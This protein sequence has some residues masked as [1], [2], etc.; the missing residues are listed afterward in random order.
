VRFDLD[1]DV[2]ELIDRGG[3][4]AHPVIHRLAEEAGTAQWTALDADGSRTDLGVLDLGGAGEPGATEWDGVL[5]PF[6]LDIEIPVGT[7]AIDVVS[8]GRLELDELMI[9]PAITSAAYPLRDG[10]ELILRAAS[11]ASTAETIPGETGSAYGADGT[12][13]GPVNRGRRELS[14]GTIAIT[15]R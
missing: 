2:Q 9:L 13:L 10:G 14:A 11:T 8:C 6:P 5:K 3:A 4:S 15:R 1:A 7:V 12:R